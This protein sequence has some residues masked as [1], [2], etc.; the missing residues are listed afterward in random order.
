MTTVLIKSKPR[1]INDCV[2]MSNINNDFAYRRLFTITL[3]G[4]WRI[5]RVFMLATSFVVCPLHDVRQRGRKGKRFICAPELRKTYARTG[6]G[7]ALNS[8]RLYIRT[9]LPL[10]CL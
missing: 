10:C 4:K 1:N 3:G 2:K 8:F 7:S 5:R 9:K 6:S